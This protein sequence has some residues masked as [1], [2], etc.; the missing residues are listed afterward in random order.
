MVNSAKK[1]WEEEYEQIEA[2]K[3]QQ[4]DDWDQIQEWEHD[5]KNEQKVDMER[6]I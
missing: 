3:R 2:W 1:K 5:P 6:Q 4:K